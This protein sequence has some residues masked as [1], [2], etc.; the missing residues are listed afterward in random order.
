[1]VGAGDIGCC[2]AL[3]HHLGHAD[4]SL[5]QAGAAIDGWLALHSRGALDAIVVTASGCGTL[6]KDYGFLFSGDGA[7]AERAA[8]VG[9]LTRDISEVL[10]SLPL[11]PVVRGRGLRVAYHAACSLR[12]GQRITE[13]PQR[14]LRAAGFEVLEIP[15][16]HLCCGSAGTY[17]LLQPE[18][19]DELLARKLANIETLRADA[20]VLGNLG[21]LTQLERGATV[22]VLH[23]VELLDWATGGPV[24]QGLE[25]QTIARDSRSHS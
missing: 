17:N 5:A 20:I 24:P 12:H 13:T 18:L 22:P 15:E 1:V 21:C 14:L 3:A 2:G 25:D 7:R 8:R 10:D 19:S 16:G 11:P 9:A 6:M 4:R 23:T